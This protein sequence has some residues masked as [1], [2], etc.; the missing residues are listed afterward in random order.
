MMNLEYTQV[1]RNVDGNEIKVSFHIDY[2]EMPSQHG[3][4][5]V[6]TCPI[7][8]CGESVGSPMSATKLV[9]QMRNHLLGKHDFQLVQG[10]LEGSFNLSRV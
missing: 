1:L 7:V 9:P 5:F 2:V 10:I 3:G 6:A 4:L 8:H